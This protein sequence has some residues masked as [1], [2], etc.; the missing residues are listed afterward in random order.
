MKILGISRGKE[1]S[2]N[3]SDSDTAIFMAVA[4]QLR[5]A[6]NDVEVVS[7]ADMD[8]SS[9]CLYDRVFCMARDTDRVQNMLSATSANSRPV[10]INAPEGILAC[11]NKA[12]VAQLLSQ[13]DISQPPFACGEADIEQALMPS[14]PLWLKNSDRSAMQKEDTFYCGDAGQLAEAIADF[15]RRGVVRWLAQEHKAGDLIKFYGVEGTDFFDWDYASRGRSKFGL[16]AINGQESGFAFDVNALKNMADK[17]AKALKTPVYGG[18]VIIDAEGR[19]YI[20]D[21]NDWP[22]F[23]RCRNAAAKAIADRIA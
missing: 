23:S 12:L 2:P 10:I 3:M 6:G 20:I 15:R 18:D 4:E 16:E 8:I 11:T 9:L 5:S 17:A 19:M 22:S 1:F 14:A 7:E 13:H 21:F